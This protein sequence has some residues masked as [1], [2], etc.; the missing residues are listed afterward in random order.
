MPMPILEEKLKDPGFTPGRRDLPGLLQLLDCERERLGELAVRALARVGEPL[1]KLVGT[2]AVRGLNPV[3]RAAWLRALVRAVGTHALPT[4]RAALEDSEERVVREAVIQ[5]AK[6]SDTRLDTDLEV[7]L[8]SLGNARLAQV[9]TQAD[10]SPA[11]ATLRAI[12]DTLG[13]VGS[14]ASREFLQNAPNANRAQMV[15]QR[16]EARDVSKGIRSDVP[17]AA[18]LWLCCRRGLEKL[19]REEVHA[20]DPTLAARVE[21]AETVALTPNGLTTLAEVLRARLW[22]T[23]VFP[24]GTFAGPPEEALLAAVRTDRFAAVLRAHGEGVQRYRVEWPGGARRMQ[25]LVHVVEAI[26]ALHSAFVNDPRGCDWVLR[27]EAN[28][29]VTMQPR[30]YADARFSYRSETVPASS[31]PTIAAALAWVA[32]PTP[33]DVVWDPFVGAGTEL[34]ECFNRCASAHYIGTDI[35]ADALAFART[36]LHG[37]PSL[38]LELMSAMESAPKNV[39]LIVSNPPMGRRLERHANLKQELLQIFVHCARLLVPGGRLVWLAPHPK[40]A[41]EAGVRA[42]LALTY[43]ES[44]DL[45]GFEAELQH[46]GVPLSTKL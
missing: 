39:S 28:G 22:H 16:R 1:L 15:F 37:L 38:Q 18:P 34:R 30:G 2:E 9:Q 33:E 36:N 44:V 20:S 26:G 4:V 35:S 24:L 45:G 5:L 42:G 46:W 32:K 14:D 13:K 11:A 10:G 25:G 21:R 43:A 31:H 27:V 19:L 40:E 29:V 6:I 8:L 17:F 12:V 23:C 41:R 3:A 7:T